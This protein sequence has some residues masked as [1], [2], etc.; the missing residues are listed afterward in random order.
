MEADF[1]KNRCIHEI[2]EEQVA[3]TPDSVAVCFEG[4]QL[5]YKALNCRANQLA[6]LLRARGVGPEVLVGIYVERSLDMVVGMLGVL[7]AGGAYIPFDP[8]YPSER[9]TFMLKDAEVPLILTLKKLA[10]ALPEHC[11]EVVYFDG[12]ILS[13]YAASNDNLKNFATP[14]NLAYVIYTSGS[15]GRPK[16][17]LGLHRGM[18][19]RMHWMWQTFPYED[20]EVFCQKAPFCFVDHI[21]EI[22]APILQGKPVAIIPDAVVRD[23]QR[24]IEVLAGAGVTRITMVATLLRMVLHAA[25]DLQA[26]LPRLKH[27]FNSGEELPVD[28][29]EAFFSAYPDANLYN[30]YGPT[31][32]SIEVSYWECKRDSK[33]SA[34]PIGYPITNTSLYLL[35][36]RL[37]PV[38][39]DVQAELHIGGVGLARGYLNRPALTAEKF[40]PDP[41]SDRPGTRL[42]KSGDFSRY[43]ADGVLEYLGRIDHQVKIRGQRIELGEIE[44]TLNRH[45]QVR[46]AVVVAREQ[47]PGFILQLIAYVVPKQPQGVTSVDLRSH[48]RESLPEAMVPAAVIF[49]DALPRTP[50]GKTNRQALPTADFRSLTQGQVYIAPRTPNETRLVRIWEEF[51]GVEQVGIDDDFFELGGDSLVAA[52]IVDRVR[53]SF[54]VTIPVRTLFDAPTIATFV[55]HLTQYQTTKFSALPPINNTFNRSAFLL[56]FAEQRLWF[57][58]QMEGAR[59]AY[60][61]Y[62]AHRLTGALQEWALEQSLAEV[63]Q[64]HDALR[65]TYPLVNGSPVRSVAS[66]QI[67]PL[68]Y[69]DLQN[70]PVEK[71]LAVAQQHASEIITEPFDLTR[72]PLLRVALLEMGSQDRVLVC[73]MHHIIS[74]DWSMDIFIRELVALYNAYTQGVPSRLEDVP[75]QYAD[76]ALWQRYRLTDEVLDA[77]LRFWKRKLADVPQVLTLP[78]DRVRTAVQTFRGR[79]YRFTIPPN[80]T[81][82]LRQVAAESGATMFM[83]LLSGFATLLANYSGER[84]MV[85][86]TPA[87][88]RSSREIESS[89]GFFVNTLVL[90]LDFSGDPTFLELLARVRKVVLEA[91][92][93]Q[94]LPFEQLIEALK[95]ERSLSHNALFQ[96]MFVWQRSPMQRLNFHGLDADYVEIETGTSIVDLSLTLQDAGDE[97][98]GEIEYNCDLFDADRIERMGGHFKVLLEAI[99][100]APTKKLSTVSMLTSQERHQVLSVWNNFVEEQQFTKKCIHHLF[101]EQAER[102]PDAIA[103]VLGNQ[104]MTYNALNARANQLAHHLRTLGVS[105]EVPVGLCIERCVNALVGLLGIIKAGGALVPLDPTYPQERLAFIVKDA[106]VS[107]ILTTVES[108]ACLPKHQ[109]KIVL[110][111]QTLPVLHEIG[112]AN[113]SSAISPDNL[114]Y[115]IYT[116]G[117]TGNPKGVAISHRAL[118]NHCQHIQAAYNIQPKDR[119]LQFTSFNFDAAVEQIFSTLVNGATLVL[120]DTSVWTVAELRSQIENQGLT[121]INLPPAYWQQ[122]VEEWARDPIFIPNYRLRLAIIGGEVFPFDSLQMWQQTPIKG[123]CLLN[124]YG[125]TEVTITSAL[126]KVSASDSNSG[127][128]RLPLGNPVANRTLYVCDP[129]G[130]LLPVGVPG[131]LYIGGSSLARGYLNCPA[132][133]AEMFVPDP[134]SGGFGAR[135]Y[136]TGDITSYLPDGQVQFYGRIDGQVKVRGF[137]IELGEVEAKL[138]QHVKVLDAVVLRRQRNT[139]AESSSQDIEDLVTKLQCLNQKQAHHL[140]ASIKN[141]SEDEV[142]LQLARNSPPIYSAG[143]VMHRKFPEFELS[144][145]LKDQNYIRPP[146]QFQRNWILQRTLDEFADDIK[147]LDKLSQRF[148]E[149]AERTEMRDEWQKMPMQHDGSQLII[150]AQQV[151]Q[152]WQHPLM[153]AMAD[154]VTETHGHVLEVGFGM[155]ISATYIQQRGVKSHTIIECND[156]VVKTFEQW[157]TG[158]PRCEFKLLQGRWQDVS[159]Q[160]GTY[161]GILFDTYPTSEEEFQKFVI[162]SITFAE[163][164]F[165]T[166]AFCLR[167]GG[168]F[169][170]YTNEIDSFSRR[171][172][173]LLFK[174]F[175]SFTLS[176]VKPLFPPQ[177]NINW[178]AD[179]MIVVKAV[180]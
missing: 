71:R 41:C 153:K 61:T 96:V 118:V 57:L 151:M 45:P 63:V 112:H 60:V 172:Q 65:T 90:R 17:V 99:S 10:Q 111:D 89:I 72:C 125:P 174:Y 42:Y 156:D 4:Y 154:I 136:R 20:G 179:S 49:L 28:L 81:R 180:K 123:A 142:E 36:D 47:K 133:T 23:P 51:L 50:S 32:A 149:S 160:L 137:R 94:D 33:R 167:E 46:E 121:V 53:E 5:T 128:N 19:N 92:E 117:S 170:Y 95:P 21:A 58:D 130:N 69:I 39:S 165:E 16:G 119:V 157:R 15:T 18:V 176:V 56:S 148:V 177:D 2:F 147:Y 29:E 115:T 139:K 83:V 161:D 85:V 164:F 171:H 27:W 86:G 74:D 75:I 91:R 54:K 35:D 129:N 152:D 6:N 145:Y 103:L 9:L 132:L 30:L 37:Q 70:V 22:F 124:A 100:T 77:Q 64:R 8:S 106:D 144:L 146:R 38:G 141:L 104:Q 162:E 78:S 25:S 67:I 178:W 66:S 52:Q 24:F 93:N 82:R 3:L 84:D 55:T 138:K 80:L 168:I 59:V 110:L 135:L 159:E 131:E 173:R 155:G 31:E 73:V 68:S 14:D 11:A 134:Y 122:V 127:S 166:A 87:S 108:S 175:S 48:L 26:Q 169:T 76:F 107:I 120:R 7:K 109:A 158:Y 126:Y 150:D 44:G 40:I 43:T 62:T 79:H 116:S 163:P 105:P 113:L 13:Q 97:L 143:E 98:I 101:E 88:T 114:A 102:T 140:L 12:E 34:V 1:P